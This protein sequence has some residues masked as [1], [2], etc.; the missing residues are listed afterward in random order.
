MPDVTL[1]QLADLRD[2]LYEAVYDDEQW[3]GAMRQLRETLGASSLAFGYWGDKTLDQSRIY[4]DCSDDYESL[5]F[6]PALS[7]PFIPALSRAETG[8]V[9]N[10]A[11]L[12]PKSEFHRTSVYNEWFVPQGEHSYLQGKLPVD[13][14]VAAYLCV[15]R[16]GQQA[17]FDSPDIAL[18]QQIAPVL[19]RV[20]AMRRR[21]GALR[22]REEAD[23]YGSL[24]VGYMVVNGTGRV[25]FVNERMGT[26]LDKP[27]SGMAI[28]GGMLA[29]VDRTQRK[30]LHALVGRACGSRSGPAGSGGDM[31]VSAPE[32]G[33][34]SLA[35]TITPMRDAAIYG[36]AAARTAVIFAQDFSMRLPPR[37][38]ERIGT[39]FKLT[40]KEASLVA[41][42]ASGQSLQEAADARSVTIATAR[43]QLGLVFRKTHTSRQSQLVSLVLSVLPVHRTL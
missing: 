3:G 18:V 7:N 5:F 32:T 40:P 36:L 42:L 25:L 27:Q 31:I 4:G 16:G 22:L 30:T 20:A 26:M 11:A 13:S 12:M 10:D 34:P 28:Q 1:D 8:A 21:F 41:G 37:F 9:Y 17:E 23:A 35:L 39:L 38:E 43:T 6:N 2:S 33:A 14:T 24:N 29:V 19:S 15:L